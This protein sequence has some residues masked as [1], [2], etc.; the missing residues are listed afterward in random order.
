MSLTLK[1]EDFA[2]FFDAPFNA[3]GKDSLYV[4]PLKSD[5]RRFLDKL[6]NPLFKGDSDLTY[7]TAHRGGS[8]VGRITA[9]VHGASN[10]THGW[11]R[12]YFGY[13]DVADDAEAAKAL[14][15]VAEDWVR[16]RGLSEIMGN[17]NLT[18]MQQVGV[19]TDGFDIAPYTDLV[20]SPPHIA[21][22][23]AE[24][25]YAPTFG[26]TTFEVDLTTTVPPVIG[27]KSQLILDDPDFTF[28]PITRAAIPQRMEEARLILNAS[29]AKN[30]MFVPVTADEFH[31][32]AKDM[33]WV[34]DPRIS[35]VLHWKGQ[36]AAC[37]ICI[38][39]LNPFLKR[40]RSRMGVVAPW[41]FLRHRWS[42]TRAVLIFSGVIPELQGR[43]VNP[44]VLRRVLLAAQ[45]AGYTDL[46]NTW[47]ADVNGPSLAQKA[48][49]GARPLHRLH[50]FHKP[51]GSR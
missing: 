2:A 38:P 40:V 51:L 7:F 11:G 3:Y 43:G 37:I 19:M 22:L 21:R 32:Q 45:K 30:P 33:K 8:V 46:A 48:K 29:F 23:L 42:S 10:R 34:M 15:T 24:N 39:D 47:I 26:M 35:A 13:F 31:F 4:S 6:Q 27:P 41:H 5:L 18:A 44:V 36:P 25:G 49:A 9:H 16:A 14:L 12:G 50:L 28:A 1:T 20:W 17:F